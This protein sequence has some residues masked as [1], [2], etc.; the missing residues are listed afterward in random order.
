MACRVAVCTKGKTCKKKRGRK[1]EEL[2]FKLKSCDQVTLSNSP[3]I[4]NTA[5]GGTKKVVIIVASY[6]MLKAITVIHE[7]TG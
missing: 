3:C 7:D 5:S 6:R 2:F 4:V 1:R